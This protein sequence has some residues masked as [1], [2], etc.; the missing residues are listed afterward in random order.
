[1]VKRGATCGGWRHQSRG[2]HVST[3][4]LVA[5]GPIECVVEL[6]VCGWVKGVAENSLIVFLAVTFTSS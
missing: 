5:G 1:M 3:Q 2:P 4:A 6:G